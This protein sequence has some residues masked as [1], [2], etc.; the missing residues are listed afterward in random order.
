MYAFFKD[1]LIEERNL[2]VQSKFL[3]IPNFI[4]CLGILGIVFYVYQFAVEYYLVAIP[5]TLCLIGLTDLL[6][7]FLARRLKQ[8]TYEGKFLDQLRDKLITLA[9]F[10]NILYL[11]HSSWGLLASVLITTLCDSI[12]LSQSFVD[13]RKKICRP[14]HWFGKVR[15]FV[16]IVCLGVVVVQI[17]WLKTEY[18]PIVALVS[19]IALLSIV[20]FIMKSR[21]FTRSK[22]SH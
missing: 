4:T 12:N 15:F 5:I 22:K 10:G 13:L 9:V 14:V 18:I 19:I 1:V 8:H 21:V 16:T 20:R 3:T 17:Y 6:D 2:E 7:G 11:G